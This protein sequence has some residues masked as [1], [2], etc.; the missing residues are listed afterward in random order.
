MR[1]RQTNRKYSSSIFE[2]LDLDEFI[3]PYEELKTEYEELLRKSKSKGE[4]Y[5]VTYVGEPHLMYIAFNKNKDKAK[6]EAT[7]FFKENFYP[8]F[9]GR[10]WRE[11]YKK[12]RTARLPD[13]DKYSVEGKIPIPE[14]MK[15]GVSFPCSVCGQHNFEYKDLDQNICFII[16][17]EGDLN[18]FT[19]GY[20]LCYKCYHAYLNPQG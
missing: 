17:D 16:E 10:G 11:M 2:G 7:K 13:F 8:S 18:I 5:K 12:A 4:A 9:V 19:K 20:I 6:G 3:K 15:L 1:R 14:L